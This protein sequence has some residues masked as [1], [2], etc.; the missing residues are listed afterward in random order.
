MYR[1][2]YTYFSHWKKEIN[3]L[4]NIS[5]NIQVEMKKAELIPKEYEKEK[6]MLKTNGT[7]FRGENIDF[8]HVYCNLSYARINF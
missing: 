4:S 6:K 1:P 7:F 5:K 8:F 2:V 3:I